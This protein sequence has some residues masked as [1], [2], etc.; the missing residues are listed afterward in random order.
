MTLLIKKIYCL[1]HQCVLV[2][3]KLEHAL[4]T[5]VYCFLFI[6]TVIKDATG[7]F[8]G[9]KL[10]I[11]LCEYDDPCD[12]CNNIIHDNFSIEGG[13]LFYRCRSHLF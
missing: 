13:Y 8:S 5:S 2:E 11:P 6:R 9:V 12:P 3:R 4:Y 1:L 10:F 7:D